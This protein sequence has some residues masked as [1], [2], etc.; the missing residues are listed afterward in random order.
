MN[1]NLFIRELRNNALSLVIWTG[2]ISALTALTMSFYGIFLENNQNILAMISILP[3]GT[4]Q[5][6]GI[7]DVNDLF[8]V[9]GFY[10]A[11][12]VIYMLVLGSIYSIVL[13]SGILLREEENKTAEFLLAW[14]L[15]RGEIFFSKAL[16][17]LLNVVVINIVT[18]VTG[19]ISLEIVKR[20]PFSTDAFLVMSVYT[21]LLN[22]FFAS[23]GL[24]M[25]TLVKKAR[26]I[27]T[28]SI[29]LVLILYFIFTISNITEGLSMI[30][31]ASPYKFVSLDTLNPEYGIELTSV[32]YF[33]TFSLVFMLFSFRL[34][35]KKDIYL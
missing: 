8:S 18:A 5:F 23:L 31:Y 12:N 6:K 13:S 29:G 27:T 11:N 4:L 33:F 28:L 16:V 35:R 9:L 14:P 25:S 34:Y 17:V 1:S 20:E 21:L 15:T 30:G 26:P 3:E 7:S 10:S 19:Y 32:L 2:V 22:L 24:F